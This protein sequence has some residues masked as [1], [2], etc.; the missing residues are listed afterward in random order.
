MFVMHINDPSKFF[1]QLT[2]SAQLP[3]DVLNDLQTVC[4]DSSS[5]LDLNDVVPAMPVIAQ[6][7]E[8][9][10][11]CRAKVLGVDQDMVRVL[12]VDYGQEDTVPL[13]DL[14]KMSSIFANPMVN[15]FQC[16]LAFFK[17]VGESWAEIATKRFEE[18]TSEKELVA[19]V[20]AQKAGVVV[21]ELMDDNGVSIGQ[22]LV[23]ENHAL[24]ADLPQMALPSSH[25]DESGSRMFGLAGD[26]SM[27]LGIESINEDTVFGQPL[28]ESTID[29]SDDQYPLL[30]LH[31]EREYEV[32]VLE[33]GTP[34]KFSI[35]LLD[36]AAHFK[37]VAEILSTVEGTEE[38]C[39]EL[40]E[41]GKPCIVKIQ[42]SWHRGKKIAESHSLSEVRREKFQPLKKY[43]ICA[44]YLS[45]MYI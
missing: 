25:G 42:G 2:S 8:S 43:L 30:K 10:Q 38:E 32:E 44:V 3:D 13:A 14:W 9:Q 36:Q 45:A 41:D 31:V 19:K 39:K 6:N 26:D 35:R 16:S 18:L 5:K 22:T 27:A 33:K 11:F 37:K 17:P 15:I 20:I 34:D 21:V 23:D 29:V 7:K 24:T 1:C 12:F 4:T 40:V 28:L